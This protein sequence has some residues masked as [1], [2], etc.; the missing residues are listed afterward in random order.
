MASNG[1]FIKRADIGEK[2]T[3]VATNTSEGT[4]YLTE[5]SQS[6]VKIYSLNVQRDIVTMEASSIKKRLVK[7]INTFQGFWDGYDS[8]GH[9]GGCLLIRLNASD[10]IFISYT[11]VKS[12]SLPK[13]DPIVEMFSESGW[14]EQAIAYSKK[15]LYDLQMGRWYWLK[16]LPI[17]E[18][19]KWN[20]AGDLGY[21]YRE[22]EHPMKGLKTIHEYSDDWLVDDSDLHLLNGVTWYDDPR[23]TRKKK[24]FVRRESSICT[25]L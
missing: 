7:T 10:Y 5:V 22:H 9:D 14:H 6:V 8:L 25:I 4:H 17:P 11:S 12:F 16:D 13:N 20:S 23:N 1:K 19:K 3:Y 2:R 21:E 15:K 24:R 18:K